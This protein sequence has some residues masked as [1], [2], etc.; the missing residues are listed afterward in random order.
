MSNAPALVWCP[1]CGRQVAA[2][3]KR[4][5]GCGYEPWS[6]VRVSPWRQRWDS[7]SV[8]SKPTRM[9]AKELLEML[10]KRTV[11][12]DAPEQPQVAQPAAARGRRV[13][14]FLDGT[15]NEPEKLDRPARSTTPPAFTPVT[16]VVDLLRGVLTDDTATSK[17][18]VIGYFRGIGTVGAKH[19]RLRQQVSGEGIDDILVD[20]YRFIAHNLEWRQHGG[21]RFDRD[22][23]FLFGFSRGAFT[24]RALSGLL[25]HVGLLK[26]EALP[27]LPFLVSEFRANVYD[28]KDGKPKPF[29]SDVQK[30]LKGMVQPEFTRIPVKFLGVWDTVGTLQSV[31]Q[32]VGRAVTP[33]KIR[34][35]IKG[36]PSDLERFH[37]TSLTE[38]VSHAY[39][40]LAIHDIRLEFAPVFWTSKANPGQ[41]VEQVWFAG[42]HS[43]VGGGYP[44]VGLST[45][46]LDWMA[47]KAR[48]VG[49]EL[50]L[51]YFQDRLKEAQFDEVRDSFKPPCKTL[52]RPVDPDAIDEY[53]RTNFD[54]GPMA[55]DVKRAIRV[56]WSVRKR[57]ETTKPAY[58]PDLWEMFRR[59]DVMSSKLDEV[60]DKETLTTPSMHPVP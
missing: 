31:S 54:E 15:G 6:S 53:L 12:G 18:Q 25:H 55:D 43:N 51:P 17:T 10:P 34:T 11:A 21:V 14:V 52:S 49:L 22:E 60:P 30:L 8:P 59:L 48:A 2:D 42:A 58:P 41:Q 1:E 7:L 56:H 9:G 24:A 28:K 46:A 40:A 4:C 26:K 50:D 20:A 44:E 29:S 27:H 37:Y 16:N 13:L 5:P 19:E 36:G 38:N 45:F 47:Y 33:S 3:S 23:V 35:L 32:A 39:Q 57:L